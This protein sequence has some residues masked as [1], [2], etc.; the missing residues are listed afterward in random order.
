M[1][2]AAQTFGF[3]TLGGADRI[4]NRGWA[5]RSGGAVLANGNIWK[6]TMT[7]KKYLIMAL[8][9]GS[10]IAIAAPAAAQTVTGNVAITGTVSN[11][12]SVL[13][14][15]GSTF[16]DSRDLGE[17][18]KVDGTL[19]DSTTLSTRFGLAGGSAPT[20]RVV[21]TTANPTIAVD[22]TE[23]TTAGS[24]PA[25]YASRIDFVAHVA[26]A[27]TPSGTG[28]VANDSRGAATAATPVGGRLANNGTDNI[29]ETADTCGTANT[30]DL[31]T[32]G[33]YTGNIAIVIAPGA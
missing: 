32:A 14:S 9:A 31:L 18:A 11:K 7:V 30:G 23:L 24:P 4:F 12:C 10:M 28:N 33:A 3:P 13:P 26:A 6:R 17:L 1:R 20:F 25:G 27:L 5:E 19:E 21:C 29:T 8:G 2:T 22:A 16:S 15:G